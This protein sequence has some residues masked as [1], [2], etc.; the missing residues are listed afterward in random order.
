MP[1]PVHIQYKKT[2]TAKTRQLDMNK[3][4]TAPAWKIVMAM[5]TVQLIA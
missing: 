4:A 2:V 1:K 5:V 3:A